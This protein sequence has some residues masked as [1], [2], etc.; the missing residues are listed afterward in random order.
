MKFNL[1]SLIILLIINSNFLSAQ[2]T[3]F[4]KYKENVSFSDIEQK[5]QQDQ[6]IPAGSLFQI[7]AELK[8]VDYLAKGIAKSNDVL[9]R[10]IKIT[11][12]DDVDE[13]AFLQLQSLDENIEYVQKATT[14]QI[15]FVP[16]DSLVSQQWALSKIQAFDAWDKT[17]GADSVLIGMID[18]GIDYFHPDLQNKIFQNPGETG[19]G[20]ETNGIDDDNNGFIDDYRGWDFTDRVGFP[21]DSSGGD[22]LGWDNDPL[23]EQGHGTY[24][25]GIAAAQTNNFTGI[26]GAAP[27]IKLMNLRAFDPGGYGEEDDVAAAIL[28]AV[29]MGV[30]VLN[31]SFGDYSFSFVLRDV[32]QFAYS[33]NMVLVGSSGNQNSS[34]PHYP[35]G[36]SEVICVGNSTQDDFRAGNSNYG[37]TLDLMAPGTQIVTTARNNNY[38]SISGTSAATPHVAAAAAL[39]LSLGNFTNEEVKQILKSTSDDIDEPGWDIF[40]GAGRLNMYRAVTVIAPSVIKFN[41]PKQDFATL[42]AELKIN[43][44]V[45]SPLFSNY[46][47]YYGYGLNPANWISLIEQGSNQFSNEDIFA[48]S[49]SS[50]PDTVYCL[51]LVVALNNGRTLEER[52]N[53]F[54]MRTSPEVT[55]IKLSA[56]GTLLITVI[57]QLSLRQC[58]QMNQP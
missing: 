55:L 41:H 36:Y 43:A 24:I 21:F 32:V 26:A 2:T 6:F 12:V 19:N 25:S 16:D 44:S 30:K 48:L 3:Y 39:I 23:D 35:S 53:F 5:V 42:D 13:G 57:R 46:S 40:T 58:T 34:L 10:I 11:F 14:Y 1:L 9:G 29:Q 56:V 28:Y 33:Q 27:N 31:M 8:S 20:K 17:Q 52:V 7:P 22:Y 45:L 47:L 37:S 18:T 49:L 54:I 51:R 15:N 4:I 50:L 38:A